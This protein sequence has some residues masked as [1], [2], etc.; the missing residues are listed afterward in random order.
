M[1]NV[2]GTPYSIIRDMFIYWD[3]TKT[4]ALNAH[5]LTCCLK[6]LGVLISEEETAEIV[7]FY[8][9]GKGTR[10]MSYKEL[11]SDIQVGEPTM[12]QIPHEDI[13]TE[14][15]VQM[16]FKTLDDKFSKKPTIVIKFL[17]AVKDVIL[18]KMRYE[19]GNPFHHIRYSFL[20]FDWN[21]SNTVEINLL[22]NAMRKNMG[23]QMSEDQARYF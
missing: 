2:G 1:R 15:D 10:E 22:C 11:L 19:G 18:R 14:E 3:S 7:D 9:D 20:N 6:Q 16:R 4:G 21:H 17:E 5:E 13:E 12:V 23:L 8:S